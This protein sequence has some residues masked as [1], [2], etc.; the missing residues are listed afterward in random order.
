M[1]FYKILSS[2]KSLNILYLRRKKEKIKMFKASHK[3]KKK[4]INI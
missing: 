2:T 4:Y 1:L 3:K